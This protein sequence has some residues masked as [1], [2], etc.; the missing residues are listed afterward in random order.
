MRARRKPRHPDQTALQHAVAEKIRTTRTQ[1]GYEVNDMAEYMGVS[2]TTIYRWE[3][4][5]QPIT[6]VDFLMIA[7]ALNIPAGAL[8]PPVGAVPP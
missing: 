5:H 7:E 3:H 8:L 6:V 1:A 4:G 2:R